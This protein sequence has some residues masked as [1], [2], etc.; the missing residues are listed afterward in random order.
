[1]YENQDI[2]L[3]GTLTRPRGAGPFPAAIMITGSGPQDRDETLMSHKPFLVIADYLT[4]R[5][6]AVLRVDDRGM[7]KSTGNSMRTSL[8]E[9]A[10][11]VLAGVNFL[12]SRKE[13][14]PKKI[15]VVG[16]SEGGVVGPLAASRSS[17][18]AF[19]V[20]LAGTG[21]TGE[22][23]LRIQGELVVR[24]SGG[25]D[26]AVK[27]TRSTQ[28]RTFAV[29]RK[30]RDEKDEKVVSD[31][32]KAALPEVPQSAFASVTAAEMRSFL[33]LDPSEA[34]RKVKVPVL[35]LNGSRDVQV[36]PQQNLPAIVA[37][38][39]AGGNTDFTVTEL[40]GLNHLFQ[41]CVTC[42]PSEYGN[43]E[44]TFS[45][46]ALEIVGDWVLKHTRP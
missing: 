39:A 37:A 23:V 21:V 19:V 14:D 3:A 25:N 44:E 18:V 22:E 35:A 36:S 29:L 34:L 13:I 1:M 16:H 10:G 38:L 24:S 2:K 32:L 40:P 8:D 43:L 20:M 9:M 46:V 31:A 5:G 4:R 7:G 42:A 11:D 33:F 41:K 45:P 6:I 26:A 17:D 27:Q 12:K 30:F 15:G 28:E